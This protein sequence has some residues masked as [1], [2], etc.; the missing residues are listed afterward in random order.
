[1]AL[2]FK[3]RLAEVKDRHPKI[4]AE[5]RGEGLLIGMRMTP[6]NGDFVAAAREQGLLTAAAGENVVRI[7]PPLIIG[8]EEISEAVKKISAACKALEASVA[9]ERGAAE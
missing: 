9:A 5:I 3:Q 2:L 8:E 4:I 7:L 1:M 6:P